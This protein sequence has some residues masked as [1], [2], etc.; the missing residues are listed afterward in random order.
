MSDKFT[1]GDSFEA[2]VRDNSVGAESQDPGNFPFEAFEFDD[3]GKNS[4]PEIR[5]KDPWVL[6]SGNVTPPDEYEPAEELPLG[7]IAFWHKS[8]EARTLT[9]KS[10]GTTD[11]DT[12]DKLVD[13]T[14]D[15]SGAGDD[16]SIGD[17]VYNSTDNTYATVQSVDSAT[18]LSLDWDAFPDGD[19][20]YEIYPEPDV[21]P[22]WI[23]FGD[24]SG[25]DI[26][27]DDPDSPFDGMTIPDIIGEE[28]FIRARET[29]GRL[30][31]DAFQGHRHEL[32]S[33]HNRSEG[34]SGATYDDLSSAYYLQPNDRIQ[35]ATTDTVNGTPRTADET[36][37]KN[38]SA[39]PILKIKMSGDVKLA[40]YYSVDGDNF[41]DL[42]DGTDLSPDDRLVYWDASTS[43]Y[44]AL[45]TDL[46]NVSSPGMYLVHEVT[47]AVSGTADTWTPTPLNKNLH[48]EIDGSTIDL[49]AHSVT[50]PAGEYYVEGTQYLYDVADAV[51]RL[52]DVTNN[53]TLLTG[54][55]I[56]TGGSVSVNSQMKGYFTLS[57]ETTVEMQYYLEDGTQYSIGRDVTFIDGNPISFSH[58]SSLHILQLKEYSI[59]QS[60]EQVNNINFPPG[61]LVTHD[62][63]SDVQGEGSDEWFPTPYNSTKHNQ[64][65]SASIDL[66]N[67]QI[68]LPAG[69]YYIEASQFLARSEDSQIRVQDVT[70]NI[71]LITGPSTYLNTSS[72]GIH[73]T[74]SGYATL[75]SQTTIEVQYWFD[76]NG[77]S[78]NL[79]R[80]N[81]TVSGTTS[82]S[83]IKVLQINEFEITYE[84]SENN[85]INFPPGL[86]VSQWSSDNE[87]SSCGGSVWCT[88]PINTTE[89]NAIPNASVD[90]STNRFTLP[91]GTYFATIQHFFMR[92][93][94]VA[95]RLHDVTHNIELV[96]SSNL[97]ADPGGDGDGI[98]TRG[99]GYFT[100]S[101]DAEIEIQHWYD[102]SSSYEIA[103]SGG[104]VPNRPVRSAHVLQINEFQITEDVTYS[105]DAN[106]PPTAFLTH[107]VAAGTSVGA[108]NADTWDTRPLNTI[109]LNEISG[110]SLSSNQITF[111]AGS[112]EVEFHSAVLRVQENKARLRNIDDGVTLGVGLSH[113]ADETDG[114]STDSSGKCRFTFT[115][116]KI[117]ELQ[118]YYDSSNGSEGYGRGEA[119]GEN[120][121]YAWVEIKKVSD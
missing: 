115:A 15:F 106:T 13:S 85:N 34:G 92:S 12:T 56:Y 26:T 32:W 38:L 102:N 24:A 57:G 60:T 103:Y 113:H 6:S 116:E 7:S 70:N 51:I 54:Q 53:V 69:T 61:L 80:N 31:E 118:H 2:D 49:T 84:V 35:Q 40:T 19:E 117:V 20:D 10:S 101:D 81:G 23:E 73:L 36:R 55:H 63:T 98:I 83:F 71:T 62:I 67:H 29:A 90:F 48:N 45:P 79:G 111:P 94:N 3:P 5:V 64:I 87:L 75:N 30:Q 93:R 14:A 110:L 82:V 108:N 86:L 58:A 50:L 66:T 68:T 89:H 88:S 95:A 104:S 97:Y 17:V 107:E 39:V 114:S 105:Y 44:K 22:G 120:D 47:S 37:P 78:W 41:A 112:Y 43:T 74:M 100:L 46:L 16:I 91:A 52:R 77:T 59:T 21:Q 42:N 65:S 25:S 109:Q 72:D 121:V 27:I 33:T 99:E 11:T 96:L 119:G 4:N 1:H 28:R 18:T 8:L 76:N 9:Q